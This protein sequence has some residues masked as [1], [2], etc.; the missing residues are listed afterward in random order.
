MAPPGPSTGI[1]TI[2]RMESSNL[3]LSGR[4]FAVYADPL[5]TK[6]LSAEE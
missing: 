3:E 2:A 5:A 6:E 1:P 4:L